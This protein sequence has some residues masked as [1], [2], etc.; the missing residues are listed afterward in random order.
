MNIVQGQGMKF[1]VRAKRNCGAVSEWSDVVY[2]QGVDQHVD[3]TH[4]D[5]NA[6]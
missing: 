1:K 6:W 3:T 4:F 2:D 5:S